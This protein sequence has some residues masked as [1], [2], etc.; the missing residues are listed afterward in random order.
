MASVFKP[1]GRHVY[2]IEFKDQHGRTRVISS[3]ATDKSVAESL[4]M[5]L[6]E[7]AGRLRAGMPPVHPELTNAYLLFKPLAPPPPPKTWAEA[8]DAY[9][10]ELARKGSKPTET[11]YKEVKRKLDRLHCECGWKTPQAVKKADFT[12]FLAQLADAGRAPRT[13]NSYQETLRAFLNW[14]VGNWE[15]G[16]NEWPERNPIATL[17][18]LKIGETGRRRLRRPYTLREWQA[19]LAVAPEPRRTVYLV[20]GLSGFRRS[21]LGRMQKQDCTPTGTRP[22]WHVRA[23]VT[24]NGRSASLPMLPDCAAALLSRWQSLKAPTARLLTDRQGRCSV[25]HIVTLHEDMEAAGID[26]QDAQGRWA[27]FH[28]FRYF[29][30]T[31]MGNRLPIQKVKEL[32]RHSTIKLTADL[33]TVLGMEDVAEEA[34]TLEPLF[35]KG[36]HT[37]S[38]TAGENVA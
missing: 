35:L 33:Y 8:Q 17:S 21:E 10:A 11:H 36:H 37:A 16:H 28:S 34:W 26:R 14:C 29:F 25:P 5:K 31:Q 38:H 20:A 12:R 27:D 4:G 9:L 24:K 30:C 2:R 15:E 6:E 19:L 7:D 32:M 23:E 18:M 13:Q 22:R 1:T 3:G